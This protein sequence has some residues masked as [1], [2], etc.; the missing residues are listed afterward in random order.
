MC[1]Y[2]PN[3][4]EAAFV[5]RGGAGSGGTRSAIRVLV[6]H[7]A[8]GRRSA[9]SARI[10]NASSTDSARDAWARARSAADGRRHAAAV[11]G[12]VEDGASGAAAG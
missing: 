12:R 11:G 3:L 6:E 8:V 10:G 7:W 2:A 9:G 4:G 5:G 1:T